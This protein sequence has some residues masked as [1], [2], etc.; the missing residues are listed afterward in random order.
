MHAMQAQ[1]V[2]AGTLKDLHRTVASAAAVSAELQRVIAE[3]NRNLT[4]TMNS[5][6]ATMTSFRDAAGRMS[7]LVDSAQVQA[8]LANLRETS[9]NAA[10]LSAGLDSTNAQIRLLLAQAE[11]GN[12][13]VGKL[14][15]DSLLYS[16]IRRLVQHADSLLADI[17][18]NPRKYINLRIF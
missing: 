14:L 1:V 17:K 10:R 15:S 18:A 13:T 12:G 6:S 5:A 2:E 16:D 8:T 3:Q 9:A 11:R 4:A 7:R